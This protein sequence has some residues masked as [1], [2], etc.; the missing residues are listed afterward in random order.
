MWT[1]LTTKVLGL[2]DRFVRWAKEFLQE[3]RGGGAGN[4]METLMWRKL[5]DGESLL[6]KAFWESE[7]PMF[8]VFASIKCLRVTRFRHAREKDLGHG[9]AGVGG[10]AVGM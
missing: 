9:L 8:T 10:F 1:E 4:G 7:A 2:S 5:W 6:S 3:S